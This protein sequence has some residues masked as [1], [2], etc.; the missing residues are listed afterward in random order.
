MFPEDELQ[1]FTAACRK[2]GA[3]V[4]D[5]LIKSEEEPLAV[6]VAPMRRQ[7]ILIHVPSGSVRRYEGGHGSHWVVDF[8]QDLAAGLLLKP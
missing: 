8:E 2:Y 5:Y 6:G 4:R 1:D 3:S 7:I